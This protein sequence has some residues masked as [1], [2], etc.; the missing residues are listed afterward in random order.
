MLQGS[1]KQ[2]R[3]LL[4]AAGAGAA[5]AL[6]AA[7]PASAHAAMVGSDPE[8]GATVETA[9]A[10][11]S[12]TFSEIL[13]GPSTE[14]AVTGPDGEVIDAGDAEYD[15]DTFSQPMLYTVPGEYTVAFRVISEDGHRVDGSVAF[16]VEDIPDDLLAATASEPTGEEETTERAEAPADDEATGDDAEATEA[17][18]AGDSGSGALIASILLGALVLVVAGVVVV[19][20]VNRRKNA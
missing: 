14:I 17:S 18:E 11:V 6:S 12:A 7:G 4:L 8:D 20:L 5:L 10:S 16:T 2:A 9:P 3:R 15:G 13:D 19:K 1:L